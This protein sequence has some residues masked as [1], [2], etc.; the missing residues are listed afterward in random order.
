MAAPTPLLVVED[1]HKSFF[2]NK[3]E[4][5]VIRGVNLSIAEG[6]MVAITG[7]S[8]AGKSTLLHVLGTL[9]PPTSGRVL[10]GR[11]SEN[12]FR[13]SEK[14]LSYFRNRMLGFV[15][16]FHYLISELTALE[17]VLMPARKL[18]QDLQKKEFAMSLLSQFGLG[19][20]M[21]RLPRQLSGGEQQRVAI[22]RALTMKPKY[23][24]ADEPTGSLDSANGEAV[25]K[26]IRESNKALGTTII[27][28]THD[29]DFANEAKRQIYLTDGRITS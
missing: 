24:F 20:K 18:R 1:L 2:K 11:E 23:L 16:Q 8:G 28:V 13:Y 4:V 5:P 25:M 22:A 10:F 3:T 27:M 7:S 14:N 19:D 29:P 17:N 12:V 26:I 9:E 21:G 15:F 6:E